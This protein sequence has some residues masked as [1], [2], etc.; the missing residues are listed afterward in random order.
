MY[1]YPFL[2]AANY[3]RTRV[4][5]S[6]GWGAFAPVAGLIYDGYGKGATVLTFLVFMCAAAALAW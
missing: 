3:G 5:G 1:Q 6:I 4:L 2:T